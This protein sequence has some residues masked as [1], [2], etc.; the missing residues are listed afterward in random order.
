M[1]RFSAM[2]WGLDEQFDVDRF[3]VW[4]EVLVA[5]GVAQAAQKLAQS[6]NLALVAGDKFHHERHDILVSRLVG[7]ISGQT[8]K[9]K[10]PALGHIVSTWRGGACPREVFG[11][12]V[13]Y[14]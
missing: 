10:P 14:L 2:G 4:L 12:L 13:K 8:N 1:L 9:R 7:S 5:S 6:K 3:G 11:T